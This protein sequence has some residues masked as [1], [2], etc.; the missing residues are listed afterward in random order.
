MAIDVLNTELWCA[1]VCVIGTEQIAVISLQ[2]S[3]TEGFISLPV[4]SVHCKLLL[5]YD[6][7]VIVDIPFAARPYSAKV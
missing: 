6:L 1:C 3:V 7:S 4:T 5:R 2:V